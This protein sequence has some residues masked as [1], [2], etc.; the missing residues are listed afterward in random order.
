M[1]GRR[2]DRLGSGARSDMF[3][4]FSMLPANKKPV[5][6]TSSYVSM[7]PYFLCL[8]VTTFRGVGRVSVSRPSFV[9]KCVCVC[10]S[11]KQHTNNTK[12]HKSTHTHTHTQTQLVTIIIKPTSASQPADEERLARRG[13]EDGD[14]W[15]TSPA[16]RQ[17][18]KGSRQVPKYA[19]GKD[20]SRRSLIEQ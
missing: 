11:T 8:H 14:R 13:H 4:M 7:F 2:P 17:G 15:T 10:V 6:Q 9:G 1:L 3:H 5:N 12:Q 20:S 18:E 19:E 16:A